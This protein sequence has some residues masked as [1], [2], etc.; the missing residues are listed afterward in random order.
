MRGGLLDAVGGD[1]VGDD[2]GQRCIG[3]GAADR[4]SRNPG[5][6]D[7][8]LRLEGQDRNALHAVLGARV[9][10]AL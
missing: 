6:G 7:S 10:G 9:D 4:N 1:E 8:R 2:P 3:A 5:R